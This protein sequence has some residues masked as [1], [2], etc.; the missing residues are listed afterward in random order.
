MTDEEP[1]QPANEPPLPTLEQ[2][3]AASD[4]FVARG[5]PSDMGQDFHATLR[6]V[7]LT[8]IPQHAEGTMA[9]L[10]QEGDLDTYFTHARIQE[11]APDEE[12]EGEDG[13]WDTWF[14]VVATEDDILK[15]HDLVLNA[16][17]MQFGDVGYESGR[18]CLDQCGFVIMSGTGPFQRKPPKAL[19]ED[20]MLRAGRTLPQGE[21]GVRF[22]EDGGT[23]IELAQREEEE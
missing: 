9:G 21:D 14:V 1:D 13:E 18:A 17:K 10:K 5:V 15:C 2:M 19:I 7:L 3:A 20:L 4:E 23:V 8:N 22:H 12:E 16:M 6:P 11:V